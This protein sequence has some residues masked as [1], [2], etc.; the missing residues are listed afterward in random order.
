ME[1][2]AAYPESNSSLPTL[3]AM[4]SF[5]LTNYA[6]SVSVDEPPSCTEASVNEDDASDATVK[7]ASNSMILSANGDESSSLDDDIVTVV[8]TQ[9]EAVDPPDDEN[10]ISADNAPENPPNYDDNEENEDDNLTVTEA[11]L[12]TEEVE[13]IFVPV[14]VTDLQETAKVSEEQRAEDEEVFDDATVQHDAAQDVPKVTNIPILKLTRAN[15]EEC[16]CWSKWLFGEIMKVKQKT[17]DHVALID[18]VGERRYITYSELLKNVNRAAN[19]LHHHGVEKGSHVAI[20]LNNSVEFVYLQ[21]GLYL[22]GAV[23]VLL[24]PGHVGSGRFPRFD[25]GAVIVDSTHYSH[26]LRLF[27]HFVGAKQIFVLTN[28]LGSLY[29][30]RFVWIIDGYGFMDFPSEYRSS[31]DNSREESDVVA[32]STSGTTSQKSKVVAHGSASAHRLCTQYLDVLMAHLI[33]MVSECR[34]HLLVTS[35][36]H[37]VDAWSLLMYS[38]ISDQTLIITESNSDVWAVSSLDRIAELIRLYDVALIT[39]NAQFLKSFVKYETEKLYGINSLKVVSYSGAPLPISVAKKFHEANGASIVHSYSTTECGPIS[40]GLQSF[41]EA[42]SLSCGSLFE[43]IN[44]KITEKDGE[45]EL[46]PG[47]WG[48]ILLQSPITCSRYF[49]GK[50]S[51]TIA[52]DHY[53]R[54]GDVGMLDEENRLYVA[55]PADGLLTLNDQTIV[56]PLLENALLDHPSVE[57]VVV[58]VMNDELTAGVVVKEDVPPP[59]LEELNEHIVGLN[60]GQLTKL[61]F[62][63]FI[64]RSET[65]KLM[66]SEVLFL[67][68]TEDD[69]RVVGNCVV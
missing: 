60:M 68:Q 67:L 53:M 19:Y 10:T 35:G 16:K 21:M 29:L 63:D 57:D 46:G 69:G 54:T 47:A 4:P 8:P 44:V 1:T 30:P 49:G 20:C 45:G 40:C 43:G 64:P 36:L 59:T 9:S 17:P 42:L 28:D 56:S 66:R 11:D 58:A 2:I 25:C 12:K 52:K 24:N 27:D 50:I 55:G 41:D 48:R 34:T 31:S 5:D 33:E 32:F 23:P 37:T 62:V 3:K 38:L 13:S 7:A 39:S 26:V 22:I 61:V 51:D 6:V 65:G 14:V 18:E 15:R